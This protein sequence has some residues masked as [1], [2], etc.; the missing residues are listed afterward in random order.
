MSRVLL[1][2]LWL[3][4]F[5]S[6][7]PISSVVAEVFLSESDEVSIALK[8]CSFV[9]SNEPLRERLCL[10]YRN[11]T[12]PSSVYRA[13]RLAEI[14]RRDQWAWTMDFQIAHK[15]PSNLALRVLSSWLFHWA[16]NS[17]RGWSWDIVDLC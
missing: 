7:S 13:L 3:L 11:V 16:R 9:A 4:G 15:A 14:Y 12:K 10:P 6:V 1:L 8:R 5:C 2:R 17:L